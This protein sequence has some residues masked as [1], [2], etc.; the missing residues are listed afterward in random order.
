MGKRC[1]NC[2]FDD[3]PPKAKYCGKCGEKFGIG[4]WGGMLLWGGL[5]I[6][7]S[8]LLGIFAL[9]ILIWFFPNI[10]PAG[11]SVY[12]STLNLIFGIIL[13]ICVIVLGWYFKRDFFDQ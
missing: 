11:Y 9:P 3:N 4:F 12:E 13:T 8:P 1:N 5:L 10:W 7:F 2:G 6:I